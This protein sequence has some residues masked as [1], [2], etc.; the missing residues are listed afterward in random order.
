MTRRP[1]SRSAVVVAAFF[2]ALMLLVLVL[3]RTRPLDA[4][5]QGAGNEFYPRI[6]RR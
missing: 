4:R 1:S 5:S 3:V 6:Y 2:F